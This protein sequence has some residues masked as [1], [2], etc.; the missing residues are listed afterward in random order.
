MSLTELLEILPV[1]EFPVNT[2]DV[3]A[4]EKIEANIGSPLP[5]DYKSFVVTYGSGRVAD[6]IYIWNPFTSTGYLNLIQ[7]MDTTLS[8]WR[9]SKQEYMAEFDPDDPPYPIF[10][11]LG[12]LLPFGQTVNGDILTWE[13]QGNPDDW[14][15]VIQRVRST[16]YEEHA[17]S[18]AQFLSNLLRRNLANTFIYNISDL[19]R[20]FKPLE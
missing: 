18:L 3:V 9:I 14:T 15:I 17:M 20:I 8:S 4:W 16:D 12:G 11:E 10:P 5:N 19:E 1:P 7:R 2:G 13:T 6:C